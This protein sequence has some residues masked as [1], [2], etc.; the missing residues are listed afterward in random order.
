MW[1]ET[2]AGMLRNGIEPSPSNV[3][4]AA[5]I[6]AGR[7]S[8]C[9]AASGSRQPDDVGILRFRLDWRLCTLRGV[10]VRIPCDG[11]LLPGFR[12]GALATGSR[13][14]YPSGAVGQIGTIVAV[15][16]G[17]GERGRFGRYRSGVVAWMGVGACGRICRLRFLP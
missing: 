13:Q 14:V 4:N 7:G 12:P 15:A 10:M 9:A 1:F 2:L 5:T 16:L 11:V 6:H 17:G 8:N 3:A